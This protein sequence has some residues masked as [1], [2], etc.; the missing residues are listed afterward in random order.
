MSDK[1]NQN[2]SE[3]K[4]FS[5]MLYQLNVSLFANKLT[6]WYF[7]KATLPY[8]CIMV[9]DSIA[10]VVAGMIATYIAGG[11]E[12]IA[13]HFWNY[14]LTFICS[15]PLFVVGMRIFHTYS[16]IMRYSSFVDLLRISG[17]LVVGFILNSIL[18]MVVPDSI[19]CE[20]TTE[21]IVVMLF[22]SMI[23]MWTMRIL[24]KYMY[25]SS[26]SAETKI[27]VFI[28]GVREGGISLAKSMRN[29]HP[30]Q[31]VVK[32]FATSE[33]DIKGRFL[34]GCE[35]YSYD[36]AL[37]GI[38]HK[39]NVK[40][41]F[42][43][44]LVTE[45][46]LEKQD[47]IDKLT[48][49]GIKIMMMPKALSWDGKSNLRHQMM[50]G[51]DIEDLL[52]RDKIEVDMKA[53]GKLLCGRTILI[54]GAA[55][56]IGSEM[57]KQIAIY[58][59]QRLILVDEAETPMHDVRLFMNKNYADI[60]C[61][62][63]VTSITNATRMERIFSEHH[64]D[65]VFHA[66][67]Y[68]HVPM[69]EDNPAEAVQNNIYGT[70]VI[71]DM[72]VKYGTKKFVMISTDKAVNPT[73]VM[74][75]SKRICEIYCQALNKAIVDGEVKGVTQFV[76]TRFGNVLGS[77]GSVIPIFKKQIAM[78]GPITVTH[79]DIIRFFMLIPEAC[80]LVLE[81]GTMGKGGEIFV[82]DMGKPVRIADLAKRMIA[83]S[84]V[85]GIDIKYVGLRDGEK[86]FEEVLNDKEATIPTHHPK[87]MVAKVREYPYELARKNEED[88]YQLSFTYDDMA[89]VKKMKEIVPEYKSQHSKY[90]QLDAQ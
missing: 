51:V 32:G 78:G 71:A 40:T 30:S 47:M 56:S 45:K 50:H 25:D 66:A 68:K 17:A 48:A 55:G 63:I 67:A 18:L 3:K 27:P 90:S 4:P 19:R 7:S 26:F 88:L 76:T 22:I 69:M 75:C 61:E 41:L 81:A 15:L 85:D 21:A 8:W 5:G 54:T 74:G 39:L 58:K 33:T 72:A 1:L 53:I 31:Y 57:V 6:N 12:L 37:I 84:G 11:G 2:S 89:I 64:P 79:P 62:T 77:N 16:G 43:S 82:F 44:P 73:N 36:E 38:M 14:L 42:V 52:P 20:L 65:Y 59:P 29:D 13:S 70:R 87:I 28:L 80:K 24:V 23:E 35:V 83:L 9:L 49:E 86:L 34:L 10:I 46:F 60:P